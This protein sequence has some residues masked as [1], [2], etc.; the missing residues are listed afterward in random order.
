MEIEV[1]PKR[2]EREKTITNHVFI[3]TGR[4]S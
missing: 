2:K 1:P 4:G 3:T